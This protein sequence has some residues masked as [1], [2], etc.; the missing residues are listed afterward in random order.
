M[1]LILTELSKY[2]I[3]MVADSAIIEPLRKPDGTIADKVYF[4]AKKLFQVSKLIAGIS[5]WGWGDIPFPGAD[6]TDKNKLERTELWLPHFLSKNAKKYNSISD[7][8]LLLEE[9]LRKRIPAIDLKDYPE[10]EGG[11]HL[12]GYEVCNGQHI[13]TFWHIHNGPSTSLP[14]KKI[15]PTIVNANNDIPL[16]LSVTNEGAEIDGHIINEKRGIATIRNGDNKSYIA[17]YNLLFAQNSP[18]SSIVRKFGLT[19][20]YAINLNDRA[21]LLKFQIQMIAGLYKFSK[22]GEGIGEPINTL[23]INRDGISA[24]S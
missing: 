11:I 5:Y 17:L 4:G 21:N 20:P 10:G 22:E 19:F 1:T 3:A 24:Y 6:W 14:K 9:E 23:I 13:P 18:F 7:L 16:N 15:D 2:G 12:A 8:S